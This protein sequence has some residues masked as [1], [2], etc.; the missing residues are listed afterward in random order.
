[1]TLE[2]KISRA[3][4]SY[5]ATISA[6]DIAGL[7]AL[8]AED[9]TV[10]DPV[11]SAKKIGKTA[12]RDFYQAAMSR[13]PKL[14]QIGETRING[15]H[16]AFSFEL[17]I[18][19]ETG[20]R[21]IQVIDT[22]VFD[23]SGKI[24]AMTAYWGPANTKIKPRLTNLAQGRY[25]LE[26][27]NG[28]TAV[29][30]GGASG[31]GL[32][33]ARALAKE[34]CNVLVADIDLE[35]A[36]KAASELSA[37]AIRAEAVKCDV[38][39]KADIDELCAQAWERFGSVELLFNNAGVM[40]KVA[41][42]VDTSED[43]LRWVFDVNVFGAWN[44]CQTFTRR[45][46]EQGTPA[47]IVNTGSENSIASTTPFCAAYNATK[48][49]VL[50]FS[51]ILRMELPDFIKVSVL[52]PGVVSTGIAHAPNS[53]P[54]KYGGAQDSLFEGQVMPGMDPDDV[55][56][57]T[58]KRVKMGDFFILTHHC[59]RYMVEERYDELMAAFDE[60]VAP[61]PGCEDIDSRQ[62]L[63]KALEAQA[64]NSGN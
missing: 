38:T 49:A 22:M 40:P 61:Y 50:G 60:Q 1:M 58:I 55:G 24:L 10:E 56:E 17:K 47:H 57:Q 20:R 32:G 9:A 25:F 26:N 54:D 34:K 43:D 31:V 41:P 48:H 13:N 23:D 2:T 11:G 46:V 42:F 19:G 12:L 7:M 21:I 63:Q 8:Y 18:D 64:E 62:L 44:V 59:I 28:K 45:F 5:I 37:L 3:V 51:G 33:I 4:K 6:G 36:E 14:V 29:V 35:G 39:N 30:T 27:L 53:R 16:A 52:C 15:P